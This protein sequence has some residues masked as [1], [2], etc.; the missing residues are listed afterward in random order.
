MGVYDTE[1]HL[2]WRRHKREVREWFAGSRLVERGLVTAVGL[3]AAF[4]RSVDTYDLFALNEALAAELWLRSLESLP[5]GRAWAEAPAHAH[6]AGG[7]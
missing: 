4:E 6:D 3:S 5:S 1:L 2:G 7:D